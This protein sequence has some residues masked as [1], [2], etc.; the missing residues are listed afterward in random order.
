MEERVI[1]V[2]CD[3]CSRGVMVW[4]ESMYKC[5]KCGRQVCASCFNRSLRECAACTTPDRDKS[6]ITASGVH[7]VITERQKE[8][9]RRRR[10]SE[11]VWAI[12]TVV[13]VLGGGALLAWLLVSGRLKVSSFK[14]W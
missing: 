10:R 12:I 6:E 11:L 13:V 1:Q 2:F 5:Q 14:F 8:Y 7:Q 4:K 9:Q 3:H